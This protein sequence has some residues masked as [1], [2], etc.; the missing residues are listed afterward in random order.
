[1]P[2]DNI[3][4]NKTHVQKRLTE[5][6]ELLTLWCTQWEF[7]QAKELSRE[8]TTKHEVIYL[9]YNLI[10]RDVNITVASIQYESTNVKKSSR[11]GREN[12]NVFQKIERPW[13]NI[14]RC[15]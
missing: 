4:L 7:W 14:K 2:K 15:E 9:V 3:T 11:V 6:T 13:K 12:D 8:Y 10:L 1:M 5:A